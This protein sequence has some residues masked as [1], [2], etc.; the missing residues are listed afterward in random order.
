P[1][2][3]EYCKRVGFMLARQGRDEDGLAWLRKAMPEADAQY[4]MARMM[5][6]IG[7]G[8][9]SRRH[10]ML[11]LQTQPAHEASQQML[12]EG[13]Q[14]P[15]DAPAV[16]QAQ[17]QP[18]PQENYNNTQAVYQQNPAL[19]VPVRPA[20]FSAPPVKTP[21]SALESRPIPV[22]PVTIDQF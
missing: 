10:L 12:M 21:V 22:M 6:H 7:Q 8:D 16:E 9:A 15:A 1:H 14:P 3:M 17:Y 18:A 5:Q 13:K 11:A 4:N 20:D 19:A 2:N